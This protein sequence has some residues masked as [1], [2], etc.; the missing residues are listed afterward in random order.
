MMSITGEKDGPPIK[1]GVALADV[2][3][4]LY[5]VI[6]ILMALRHAERTGEGQH[7]DCSLLDTQIAMLANQALSFLVGG[8]SPGRLGNAHPTIVPYRVFDAQGGPIVIA[9]GNNRQFAALCAVLGV[10][11]LATD[12]RYASNGN[13]VQNRA[14]L[15]ATLQAI[16]AQR[17]VTEL[18]DKLQS[19]GVPSGPVNTIAQIFADPVVTARGMLHYFNRED[20]VQVPSVAFPG[21]MSVTPAR[22]EQAPP[23]LGEHTREILSDWL[24]LG[25]TELAA[26]QHA[27]VI[28]GRSA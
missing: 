11:E 9:V 27:G 10:P 17:T 22:F 2:A 4:G 7:I 5:A 14:A 8:V 24:A 13:R 15:E 1:P 23:Q 18:M 28:A 21:K 26:L 3:T 19:S 16:V 6:S 20:A 12:P 25:P